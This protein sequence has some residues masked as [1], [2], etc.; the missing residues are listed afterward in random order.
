MHARLREGDG[1]DVDQPPVALL[2]RQHGLQP[3]EAD[4][5]VDVDMAAHR[6]RAEGG[7]LLDQPAAALLDRTLIWRRMRLLRFN[8]R[9]DRVAG[10]MRDERQ[11]DQRLVEMDVSVD[12]GRREKPALRGE[13]RSADR[14]ARPAPRPSAAIRP[15]A[16][17]RSTVSPDAVACVL[18][19]EI[20]LHA[21]VSGLKPAQAGARP[22]RGRALSPQTFSSCKH[23]KVRLTSCSSSERIAAALISAHDGAGR[24]GASPRCSSAEG[25]RRKADL[26][27]ERGDDLPEGAIE[28]LACRRRCGADDPHPVQ[29][30]HRM[31][32]REVHRAD[33]QRKRG[34][35]HAA[36]AC[37]ARRRGGR[38]PAG[39]PAARPRRGCCARAGRF[40]ARSFAR[41][42]SPRRQASTSA[43]SSVSGAAPVGPGSGR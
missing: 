8:P 38:R 29:S 3:L 21:R 5:R 41:P 7:D 18:D 17:T 2:E 14:R 9:G 15:S 22:G 27:H 34:R 42:R 11:A 25:R 33:E 32:R 19:D 40:P 4:L 31:Q 23:E 28:R 20:S 30:G 26:R 6:E 16:M 12:E 1:L 13:T 35:G 37:R 24:A 10:N 39:S 36:T 43:G